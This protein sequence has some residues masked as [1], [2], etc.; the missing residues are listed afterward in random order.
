MSLGKVKE[1]MRIWMVQGSFSFPK[2][3]VKVNGERDLEGLRHH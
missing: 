2:E 1:M 3:K